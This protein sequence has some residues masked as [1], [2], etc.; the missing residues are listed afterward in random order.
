MTLKRMTAAHGDRPA[1]RAAS[2]EKD[3]RYTQGRR[4]RCRA[5]H[6]SAGPQAASDLHRRSADRRCRFRRSTARWPCSIPAAC[7]RGTTTLPG[8]ARFELAEWLTGHHHHLVCVDCNQV[9]DVELDA[10][11]ERV[12]A[13]LAESAGRDRGLCGRRSWPRD[14]RNLR[15]MPRQ[16]T[17]V[18]GEEVGLRYRS[19]VALQPS[20]FTIERGTVATLIGPNGSGKSTM[21]NAI[22]GLHHPDWGG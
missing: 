17:A 8:L 21:L 15:P 20:D 13:V 19:R 18:E 10:E 3:V 14:R 11:S 7:F 22:A 2:G 1:G 6:R 5:L 12:L 4:R 9:V 16:V